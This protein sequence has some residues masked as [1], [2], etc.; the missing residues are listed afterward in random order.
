MSPLLYTALIGMVA[1]GLAGR[2][3]RG[4]GMGIIMNI[5]VGVAG[6]FVGRFIDGQLNLVSKLGFIEN[7]GEWSGTVTDI[8]TATGGALIL[9]IIGGIFRRKK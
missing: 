9:L 8:I 7:L 3:L 6:A 4:S 1:G 5:L 2:L